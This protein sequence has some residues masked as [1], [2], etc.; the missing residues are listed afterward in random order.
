MNEE[1]N[2]QQEPPATV[3]ELAARAIDQADNPVLAPVKRGRGRPRKTTPPDPAIKL[4]DSVRP[5]TRGERP[6]R[7]GPRPRLY[8]MDKHGAFA[9]DDIKNL[10]PLEID[11]D[12]FAI[13]PQPI[14]LKRRRS[15]LMPERKIRYLLIWNYTGGNNTL[16][17][18]EAGVMPSMPAQWLKDD[19]DFKEALRQQ[20][21]QIADRLHYRLMTSLGLIPARKGLKFNLNAIHSV[22]KKM[23]PDLFAMIPEEPLDEQPEAAPEPD[24]PR[25][26]G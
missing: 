1:T 10:P 4:D 19:P 16:A 2:P 6:R 5:F 21:D 22:L 11:E 24:V 14:G 15:L 8:G 20:G 12:G 13:P 18:Q 3:E 7:K 17:C 23:K 26:T 25:P 9:Y